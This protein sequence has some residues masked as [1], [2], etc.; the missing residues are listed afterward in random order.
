MSAGPVLLSLTVGAQLGPYEILSPLGAGGM[1]LVTDLT[2]KVLDANPGTEK[3]LGIARQA[4]LGRVPR[5]FG[6]AVELFRIASV[7]LDFD[8]APDGLRF[9]VSEMAKVPGPPI[10]SS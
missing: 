2:G 1:I 5:S 3:L 9:L 10:R 6:V 8:A 7:V 4:M